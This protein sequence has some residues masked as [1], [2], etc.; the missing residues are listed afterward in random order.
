MRLT[1]AEH[2]G[3]ISLINRQSCPE[4][5]LQFKHVSKDPRFVFP[6]C[7]PQILALAPILPS[8]DSR[9]SFFLSFVIYFLHLPGVY[10]QVNVTLRSQNESLYMK[11]CLHV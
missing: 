2:K 8:L 1:E 6:N 5:T 3:L 7:H 9:S 10:P 4:F 11:V